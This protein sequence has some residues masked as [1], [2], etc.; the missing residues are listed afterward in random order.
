MT[1]RFPIAKTYDYGQNW[2]SLTQNRNPFAIVVMA[3][4]K[5]METKDGRIRKRWKLQLIR[6]LYER[7]H[8]RADVLELF[9]FIDWLLILPK[10]LEKQFWE[11]LRLIEEEKRMPYV[12][13]VERIGIEKGIQQGMQQ[14][15][16]QGIQQGIEQGVRQG[17]HIG[18]LKEAREMVIDALAARF[19]TAP[20]DIQGIVMGI[21][22]R[23]EL[24][25]LHQHAILCDSLETF[26]RRLDSAEGD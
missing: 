5:A 4:L 9:R 1:F 10:E 8:E 24:K 12:T 18:S 22:V 25:K 11:E 23:E 26:R 17:V 15:V 14:G 20:R 16:R 7:G 2:P 13:S 19:G 3:H 21:E 6:M